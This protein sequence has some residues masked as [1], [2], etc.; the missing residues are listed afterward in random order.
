MIAFAV[1][2]MA[3]MPTLLPEVGEVTPDFPAYQAGILKGDRVVEANGTRSSAG[4]IWPRSS[5]TAA[6]N[7]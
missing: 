7:R 5:M 2:F 1:I 3:G 6:K 4:M